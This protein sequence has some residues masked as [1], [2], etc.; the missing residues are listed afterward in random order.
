MRSLINLKFTPEGADYLDTLLGRMNDKGLTESE[1]YQVT[2]LLAGKKWH[3]I[4]SEMFTLL[5]VGYSDPLKAARKLF[6]G[7]RYLLE[8]KY[9]V[10]TNEATGYNDEDLLR[11]D[12]NHG[13]HIIE[14]RDELGFYHGDYEGKQD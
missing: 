14:A 3:V 11:L 13:Q 5:M 2:L 7:M 1:H 4:G 9:M 12:Y 10:Q 8:L 6:F